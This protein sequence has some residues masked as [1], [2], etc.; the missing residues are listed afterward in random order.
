[1]YDM[2]RG[3]G[4]HEVLVETPEHGREFHELADDRLESVLWAYRD[5]II[6]L[7]KDQRFRY[8]LVF[9]NKGFAAGATISHS[10]SQIIATPIT[11]RTVRQEL[12]GARR[13]FNFNV[14][15][16]CVWCDIAK[17]ETTF[18]KRVVV[19]TGGVV[20]FCP[21][22]SRFPFETWVLPTK[23]SHDFTAA[24][25][26]VLGDLA[27]AMK[28]VLSR[29]ETALNYPA[30]N[31]ILHTAP[32]LVPRPG[33]WTTIADDFHWHFEIIPRLTRVKGFEWGTGFYVNPTPPEL[34]AEV[35]RGTGG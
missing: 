7:Q 19:Q 29:L 8:V 14:R 15:E 23:H 9:K 3:V 30:Y 26:D 33:Y 27:R 2:T 16:R 17:E 1:M 28:T 5:R 11:P 12:E 31:F 21:Y 24:G 10:H 20:A 13:Y 25:R 35:L 22:S 18:A 34:A 32:N 6:D 4:A